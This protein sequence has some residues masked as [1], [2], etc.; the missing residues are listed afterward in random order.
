M[1]LV[2]KCPILLKKYVNFASIIGCEW[3]FMVTKLHFPYDV[4][5]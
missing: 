2:I 5:F 4:C 3:L 1:F